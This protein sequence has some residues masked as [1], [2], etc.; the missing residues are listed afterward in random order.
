MITHTLI[1]GTDSWKE[2]RLNHF[3]A[4]DAPAM[5]GISPH[6]TRTEL[7]HRL[8]T[9]IEKEIDERTQQ[10]FDD[11]HRCEAL[12]RP[13]AEAIVGDDLYPVVVTEGRL[14]ASLDGLDS[15]DRRGFEHKKLN[16]E[17]REIFAS[18][19]PL[20]EYH[21]VQM[22]QQMMIVTTCEAILFMASD[23]DDNDSLIEELHRWYCPDK[24]LR[25]RIEQGWIQLELDKKNY[26]PPEYIPAVVAMPTKDLPALSIQ[27][28]GSISLISNLDLFGA[29]LNEFIGQINKEPDDDQGFADAEA[30]IKVLKTAEDALKAS[31]ASALAQTADIDEMRK[32]V[33]LY[34]DSASTTRKLL[35]NMVVE[36]K[37]SIKL[38]VIQEGK[39]AYAQHVEAIY[40]RH[41]GKMYLPQIPADFAGAISGAKSIKGL[42]ERMKSELLRV[43]LAVTNIANKIDVNLNTLRESAKDHAFL[44]ADTGM[45]VLKENEDLVALIKVRISEHEQAVAAKQAAEREQM[46]IEEEAKAKAREDVLTMQRD[47]ANCRD[48]IEREKDERAKCEAERAAIYA[49]AGI[50]EEV[51]H[52]AEREQAANFS[53][54]ETGEIS[55]RVCQD[56]KIDKPI[57][58][59]T[60]TDEEVI[61]AVMEK[62]DLSF[63]QACDRILALL[64]N[65]T[66][67]AHEVIC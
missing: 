39:D 35:N 26:V 1:Q 51:K 57:T 65:M 63:R 67:A 48:R 32:T 42:R 53:N 58:R 19:E 60:P 5:L 38:E 59:Q 31:E 7:L 14:S 29:R 40:K 41:D 45:L 62:F 64:E 12:A 13:L 43:Q 46:R 34:M 8:A 24:E 16:A 55:T 66:V 47:Q 9:G 25:A 23:W 61:N 3:N 17:I 33:K 28:N 21:R 49:D 2:H 54:A 4:S 36:R 56:K 22:E 6:E 50:D 11:G 15:N 37:K 27:V 52:E 10:R 20:L 18:D 44:F 30:A